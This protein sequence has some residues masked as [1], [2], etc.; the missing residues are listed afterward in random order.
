MYPMAPEPVKVSVKIT[1]RPSPRQE[2]P[3]L[4]RRETPL[5]STRNPA[6]AVGT[7]TGKA[8]SNS[9]SSTAGSTVGGIVGG[10]WRSRLRNYRCCIHVLPEKG[11]SRTK[12]H[13][14]SQAPELVRDR[15]ITEATP[16]RRFVLRVVPTVCNCWIR[17]ERG[18]KHCLWKWDANKSTRKR[19][20]KR[21][22]C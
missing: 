11:E 15:R 20:P 1:H 21:E 4:G 10:R 18:I 19:G 16:Q 12:V 14:L 6:T 8:A 13:N 2:I 17:S 7:A 3:R 9:E 5:A 22:G